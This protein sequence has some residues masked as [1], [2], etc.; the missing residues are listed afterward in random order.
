MD[1][2]MKGSLKEGDLRKLVITLVNMDL[3]EFVKAAY[4][5]DYEAVGDGRKGYFEIKFQRFTENPAGQ[6]CYLDSYNM[7]RFALWLNE[8]ARN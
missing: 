8:N 6:M 2:G 4:G 7:E 3:E 5:E 1:K